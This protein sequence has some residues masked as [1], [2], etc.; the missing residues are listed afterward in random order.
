MLETVLNFNLWGVSLTNWLGI[1]LYWLPLALC[2]YGYTVRVWGRYQKE[3][4]EREEAE[5]AGS[6]FY[7][8]LTV[9]SLV[10]YALLTITPI[11]NLFSAIFDVAP[12]VFKGLIKLCE[13]VFSVPLVSPVK[14][15][16]K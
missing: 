2:A 1:L 12:Q 6:G 9:G 4:K 8:T 11:A 5:K 10:G 16:E 15:K 14:R 3:V 7:P 13:R